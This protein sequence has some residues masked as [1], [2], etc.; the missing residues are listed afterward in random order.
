MALNATSTILWHTKPLRREIA[1]V[2]SKKVLASNERQV[3]MPVGHRVRGTK[4][5]NAR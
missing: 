5:I 3:Y 2:P 4:T 1:T